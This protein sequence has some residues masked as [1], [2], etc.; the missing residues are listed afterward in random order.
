VT[1][2]HPSCRS[3]TSDERFATSMMGMLGCARALL[4]IGAVLVPLA[5]WPESDASS[6][7]GMPAPSGG[8]HTLVHAGITRTYGL[9]V[10]S[11]YASKRPARLVLVFHG[12]GADEGEFLNDPTVVEES[13]RRGYILVAPRGLG[14]G[15]PDQSNNS[16]TFRGSATGIVSEGHTRSAI[17]DASVTPNYTY[18]SCRNGRAQNSCSWTQCQDDDVDFVLAL[19]TH[20]EASLCVDR[21]H[22]FAA[23]GSNGGM[24]TWEVGQNPRTAPLLRAIASIVGLPHRGDLR[25]PGRRD[26]LPV[27]LISGLTD[28]TVPPGNWDDTRYT[29]TSNDQDRFYYTGATAIVKR[30]A[31]ADRCTTAQSEHAFNMGYQNVE[32]RTYCAAGDRAPPEVLDCRAPMGHDYGLNWSWRLILD[33]FD[34]WS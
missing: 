1:R 24:F 19:I 7:C 22:I 12:W 17:C 11:G 8:I 9:R 25:P 33:F 4:S 18:P 29:T 23:G 16:W 13:S 15:A 28:R 6:G 21:H 20:I 32:C 30:W 27:L 26:D 34:Q 5:A 3:P 14:S 2:R 31:Q 10:P